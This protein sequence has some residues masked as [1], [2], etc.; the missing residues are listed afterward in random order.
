MTSGLRLIALGL[1]ATVYFSSTGCTSGADQASEGRQYLYPGMSMDE[2]SAQLGEP[3][4][5]I[6]T[7]METVWIYR[8]EGG[9]N[10]VGTIALVVVFVAIVALLAL[11]KSGGGSFGGGG[12]GGDG[13][14]S[15]I[16]VR[17]GPDNRLIDVS[18]PEPV[19][20]N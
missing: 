5:I 18:A 7:D 11:S 17:F 20:G 16:R 14:P 19:P 3:A 8:F 12:G 1:C 13:P 2:V 10:V 6:T 4:Q 15:Q 9:T